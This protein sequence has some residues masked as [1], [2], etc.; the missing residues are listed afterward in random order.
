MKTKFAIL[1]T[2]LLLS[3]S[4]FA[5]D[6]LPKD[7]MGDSI[8]FPSPQYRESESH[9][10][11]TAAYAVHP[12]G[13]FLREVVYRPLSAFMASNV[14]TRSVFGYRDPYDFRESICFNPNASTPDCA[15]IPPY[16]KV[17]YSAGV[18]K[19]Y[20]FDKATGTIRTENIGE[21]ESIVQLKASRQIYFPDI[22]FESASSKL[23]TLGEGRVRQIAAL[24][25]S[26]PSLNVILEGN[27]DNN[28]SA[29]SNKALGESRAKNVK[30]KL[31]TLGI[32]ASRLDIISYGADNPIFT[33][34]TAWA[35]AVNRRVVVTI[36]G[37]DN[38]IVASNE[39]PPAAIT[40]TKL[41]TTTIA[42]AGAVADPIVAPTPV[43]TNNANVNAEVQP[44]LLN[45]NTGANNTDI[46]FN[47]GINAIDTS[48][49]KDM[50]VGYVN[51]TKVE[52]GTNKAPLTNF[53]R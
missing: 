2:L 4:V 36:G 47:S 53:T 27:T 24:L 34:N 50:E 18:N 38:R 7:N 32:D 31:V 43:L 6:T 33:E 26:D 10:L 19:G 41:E 3:N 8:Y 30:A 13:Y 29:Q 28:G 37:Q 1:S 39:L 9:P 35:D 44:V 23:S 51:N 22:A 46:I 16:S 5:Q 20:T 14:V 11:R 52:S 42:P 12:I 48:D 15:M 45:A 49:V 21:N 40:V 17:D 25:D